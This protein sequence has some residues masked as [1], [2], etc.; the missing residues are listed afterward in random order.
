MK[1]HVYGWRLFIGLAA[2]GPIFI[3]NTQDSVIIS[4]NFLTYVRFN[5]KNFEGCDL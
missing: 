1:I 4:H 2:D 3:K 5:I